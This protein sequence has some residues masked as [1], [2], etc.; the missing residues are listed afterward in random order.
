MAEES[1]ILRLVYTFFLGLL[2][3]IF[4]G[5]GIN[6]FYPGPEM[7][8]YPSE[9]N[10]YTNKEMTRE[11]EVVQRAY[12]KKMDTWNEE[13]KP[14]SRNVSIIAMAAALILLAISFIFEKKIRVI[15]DGVM[16]GGLFTLLYAIIRGTMSADSKYVFAMVSLGLIIVL[17]LG[18]HRFVKPYSQTNTAK[19]K[20]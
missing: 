11:Q 2:L 16:L 12:D 4:V 3:A 9:L 14:Y 5:F 13:M 8:K 18:Y 10:T 17:Y 20:K 15:A 19:T 6:T 1:G 7:P